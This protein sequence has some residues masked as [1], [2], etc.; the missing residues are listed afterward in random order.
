M[1]K[2]A[3]DEMADRLISLHLFH[4][5]FPSQITAHIL[6][7]KMSSLDR[8]LLRKQNRLIDC[9]IGGEAWGRFHQRSTYSFFARRSRKRKNTV[10]S[11]VSFYAFRIYKRK[12]CT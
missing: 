12:S 11:S 4:I 5:N 9:Q 10:K 2:P 6:L 3:L 7:T 8:K 1:G